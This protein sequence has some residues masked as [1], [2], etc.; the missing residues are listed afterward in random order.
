MSE[1]WRNDDRFERGRRSGFAGDRQNQGGE[2]SHGDDSR[3]F[4]GQYYGSGQEDRS[5]YSGWGQDGPRGYDDYTRSANRRRDEQRSSYGQGSSYDPG[6]RYG[7][8]SNYDRYRGGG[9]GWQGADQRYSAGSGGGYESGG[10]GSGGYQ[11]WRGDQSRFD[12]S[13]GYRSGS[14]Y[15][16]QRGGDLRGERED[17]GWMERAGDE[18][19]S[20]FG[21]EDAERRRQQ[22]QQHRGRGPRGYT[23]SDE[24][25]REDVCDRLS[26][27]W[28]IDASDIEVQ[29]QGG[30][31]TLTGTVDDRQLKRRA[32]DVAEEISGVRNVQNN[33]RIQ[34]QQRQATS[35]A[36]GAN[37]SGP[38]S[39]TGTT[40]TSPSPA[41]RSAL[42]GETTAK[43]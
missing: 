22:D 2:R 42:G 16:D 12:Q 24:R 19:R 21:D 25:I 41:T 17:R 20:W 4:G 27:D 29:V 7:Q 38:S 39:V 3:D 31:V 23:R 28:R 10:Y 9:N 11:G 36:L 33:L 13:G 43:S 26:D 1:R 14:S 37:N 8:G 30:E 6:D 40:G 15:G 5:A 34:G 18:V 32:E 35:A